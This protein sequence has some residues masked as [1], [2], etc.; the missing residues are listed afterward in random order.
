ML[1]VLSSAKPLEALVLSPFKVIE[2]GVLVCTSVF[3][4]Y[5]ESSKLIVI[6]SPDALVL[7]GPD[8]APITFNFPLHTL[9]LPLLLLLPPNC[10][11]VDFNCPTLTASV[12]LVPPAT[13]TI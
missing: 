11:V 6:V 7:I 4:A 5:A 9:T 8:V 13:P 2:P 3:L 12:S 1:P 10:N